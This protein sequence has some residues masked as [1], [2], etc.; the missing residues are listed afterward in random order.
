MSELP[1][2]GPITSYLSKRG[3]PPARS[4]LRNVRP[5]GDAFT[6]HKEL[7]RAY[8]SFYGGSK[9]VEVYKK[10]R[11]RV[12]R[13]EVDVLREQHRFLRS[14]E[15][16]FLLPTS[17]ESR[18]AKRYYDR[19]FREFALCDL[20]Y[21]KQGKIALRWRTREE[22]EEGK[23]QFEC[24]NLTCK[25]NGGNMGEDRS[26]GGGGG[27]GRGDRE[28][29]EVHVRGGRRE[30]D[31]IRGG[32]R[33]ML[34]TWEVPFG[35]VEAGEKKYALVK[36]RLC[37][38]CSRR[39]NWKKDKER[40]AKEKEARKLERSERKRRREEAEEDRGSE[41]VEVKVEDVDDDDG[42][43]DGRSVSDLDLQDVL[44]KGEGEDGNGRERKR[45]RKGSPEEED[46][47]A[48]GGAGGDSTKAPSAHYSRQEASRIWSQP[49]AAANV[50]DEREKTREEEFEDFLA[51]MFK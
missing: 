13:S 12:Q 43:V 22:V 20:R 40:R 10:S 26:R 51:E 33:N 35:Y 3:E 24:G 50:N 19:L 28:E 46:D 9:D 37:L 2:A 32:D 31:D 5:G 4:F 8:A 27:G 17:W 34:K 21:Y 11:E 44:E 1:H 49:A 41:D 39:L 14:E 18:L 29:G 47:G 48:E 16:D 25:H 36:L 42:D 15:D 23:G 45:R 38:W 6:A 30:A 7:M